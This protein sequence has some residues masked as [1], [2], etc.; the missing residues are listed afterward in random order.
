VTGRRP[1]EDLCVRSSL[2]IDV[3]VVCGMALTHGHERRIGRWPASG[4][5]APNM[6][7][8]VWPTLDHLWN[9]PDAQTLGRHELLRVWLL[10][11][12]LMG[13]RDL[14]LGGYVRSGLWCVQSSFGHTN[15][16]SSRWDRAISV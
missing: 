8:H 11:W 10:A 9:R 2:S 7:G 4:H 15:R 12:W 14:T 3:M 5:G 16:R 6:S 1:R 13:A